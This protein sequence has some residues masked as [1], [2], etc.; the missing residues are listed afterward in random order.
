MKKRS[1]T[2]WVK[3]DVGSERTPAPSTGKALSIPI[4]DITVDLQPG[5]DSAMLAEVVRVLKSC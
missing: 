4:N 1:N 3:V 2:S 5:F